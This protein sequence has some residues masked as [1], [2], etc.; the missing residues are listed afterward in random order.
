MTAIT[1]IDQVG[2]KSYIRCGSSAWLSGW[3][4]YIKSGKPPSVEPHP[5]G[6]V[7]VAFH[8]AFLCEKPKPRSLEARPLSAH[9]GQ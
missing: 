2:S 7:P 3:L 9:V 5:L 6:A 4:S 8:V 1:R